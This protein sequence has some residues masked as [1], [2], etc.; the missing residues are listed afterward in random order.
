MKK[1]L[2][3]LF[4][5]CAAIVSAQEYK[6]PLA[7]IDL[8]DGDSFIFLGDSITHQC[9]YTQYI[10]DYYYTRYPERRLHFHN[11]GVGGDRAAD[12][13]ARFDDDVAAFKPKYVTILLGMNDGSY[14]NFCPEIFTTYSTGMTELLDKLAAIGAAAIPMTPTMFDARAMELRPPKSP[15]YRYPYYNAVLAFYG[16][17]LRE[18]AGQRGLGFVNMWTPLNDITGE[19]R[20]KDPK[21]TLI[22]DAIHPDA[23]GQVI[24]ATS[25]V[26]DMVPRTLVSNI[27][28]CQQ[29]K[30]GKYIVSALNGKATDLQATDNNITFTFKANALPWVVPTNAV[31]GCDLTHLGHRYSN[32]KIT[33]RNLK[34]GK[35]ELRIDDQLIGAYLDGQLAFGVELEGNAKTPQ[36]QQALQVATLNKERNEKAVKPL[37]DLWGKL[38]GKRRGG[39]QAELDKWLPEFKAGVAETIALAKQY[40]D[41]I[42]QANQPVA[43]KYEITRVP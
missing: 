39:N 42:Y 34:P 17:W 9:L 10:E 27:I 19:Q 43:R 24:M 18:V 33:V 28:L 35:Y 15:R 11:A 20:K 4:V 37:R 26:N 38:K 40:E 2:L 3:A 12:A 32:E 21:F 7:A 41:Q 31:L 5:L 25:I 30:T 13:L 22:A 14:T 1:L 36:Y 29:P 23:P 6:Q 16:T 8:K